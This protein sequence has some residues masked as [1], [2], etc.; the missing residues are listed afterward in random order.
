MRFAIRSAA[1]ILC[2]ATASISA[3]QPFRPDI[4]KTWDSAALAKLEV[5]HPDARYSPVPVSADYYYRVP[6]R[7]VY[8]TYPVYAP[9]REP[10]R[11]IDW[12]REQEPQII[13]EPARLLTQNDW[14][15]AGHLV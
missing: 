8:K 9:G 12:L 1:V 3:A 11:Y 7:P 15:K 5:P 14:I 4:P 10:S 6:V 2:W 13:F